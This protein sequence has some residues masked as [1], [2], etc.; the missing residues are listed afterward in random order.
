MGV[1]QW[2]K[3]GFSIFLFHVE[4]SWRQ[5]ETDNVLTDHRKENIVTNG[6]RPVIPNLDE[7]VGSLGECSEICHERARTFL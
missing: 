3:T 2:V 5:I 4:P 6:Q 7:E 1:G